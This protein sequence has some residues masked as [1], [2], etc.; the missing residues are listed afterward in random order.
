M[1][2]GKASTGANVALPHLQ[3]LMMA[4]LACLHSGHPGSDDVVDRLRSLSSQS[5]QFHSKPATAGASNTAQ[6]D[7]VMS[8]CHIK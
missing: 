8:S 3:E 6:P 4:V 2:V 5:R 7:G 1:N